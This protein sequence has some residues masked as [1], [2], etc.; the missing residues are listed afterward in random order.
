[1][2]RWNAITYFPKIL[3]NVS[4]CIMCFE[5]LSSLLNLMRGVIWGVISGDSCE[6]DSTELVAMPL[7]EKGGATSANWNKSG[8]GLWNTEQVEDTC[9]LEDTNSTW[10]PIFI[11]HEVE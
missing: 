4:A 6:T 8:L 2:G 11:C 10:E 7:L 9:F 1:M 5:V 3:R